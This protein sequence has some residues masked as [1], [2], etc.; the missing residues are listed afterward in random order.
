MTL[1]TQAWLKEFLC[2]LSPMYF[3]TRPQRSRLKANSLCCLIEES[4]AVG[5]HCKV[6]LLSQIKSP[7]GAVIGKA[8]RWLLK[9][10]VKIF[11]P[12]IIPSFALIIHFEF[13]LECFLHTNIV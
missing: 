1:A 13:N 8:N 10:E 6:I 3:N 11:L 12:L 5:L 7:C 9:S 4:L 2:C